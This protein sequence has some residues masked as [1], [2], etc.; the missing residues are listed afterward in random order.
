MT[1]VQVLKH[2]VQ[3]CEHTHNILSHDMLKHIVQL[4]GLSLSH[5]VYIQSHAQYTVTSLV[6]IYRS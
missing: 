1:Y 2:I 5:D 3:S 4:H 6:H